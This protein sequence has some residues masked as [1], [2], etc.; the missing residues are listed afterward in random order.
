VKA[1]DTLA[2]L[3]AA[4]EPAAVRLGAARTI[5]TLLPSVYRAPLT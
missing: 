3:L 1:V 2:A 5:G 4:K